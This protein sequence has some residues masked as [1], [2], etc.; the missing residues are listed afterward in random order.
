M[1]SPAVPIST[2]TTLRPAS[3]ICSVISIL[4][5]GT[6]QKSTAAAGLA[7]E[8]KREGSNRT[9][10]LRSEAVRQYVL[11]RAKGVCELKRRS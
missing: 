3:A 10:R 7:R 4:V 6:A 1:T 5:S 9:Y 2:T 8:S 11:A